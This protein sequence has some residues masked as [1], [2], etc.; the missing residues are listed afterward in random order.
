MRQFTGRW[1][2]VVVNVRIG[3]AIMIGTVNYQAKLSNFQRLISNCHTDYMMEVA[4]T[5]TITVIMEMRLKKSRCHPKNLG[6]NQ[7]TLF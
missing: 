1:Q 7:L 5:G 2:H 4:L 3:G 6:L